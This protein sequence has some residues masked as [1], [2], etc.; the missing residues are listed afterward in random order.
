ME[1]YECIVISGVDGSGKTTLANWLVRYLRSKG[2]RS[3]Y[4]W[5][6]SQHTLAYLISRVLISLG[7]CQTFKNPKGIVITR[8]E[9]HRGMFGENI[10][11]LIEFVSVLPLIIFKVKLP[12]L[13]GYKIVLDRYTIDTTISIALRTRNMS[14]QH[15][16][17]GRLL[18][19]MIPN[20]SAVILLNAD[21]STVLERRPDVEYSLEEIKN[22]I[23]LYKISAR[24]AK[25][26][27][28]NT[29]TLTIEQTI[30]KVSDFLLV[31]PQPKLI[32]MRMP[33]DFSIII[34]TYNRVGKLKT[35]L[36]SI[37]EQEIPPKEVIIVDQSHNSLTS[38]LVIEMKDRYSN[39]QIFLR[40]FHTNQ[41][42]ASRA[43]NLGIDHSIGEIVFFIDDDVIL[44]TD[45]TRNILKVYESH[46]DA[47]GVQ[48]LILN[49]KPFL[50]LKFF[51]SRLENHLRRALFLSHYKD[52]TWKIMPS[53]NDVLP[54][55]TASI[56]PTQRLQGCCSYKRKVLEFFRFDENLKGWSFLED[57]DLSYRVYKSNTGSLY[58]TPDAKLIHKEH[59]HMSASLKDESY[60]KIV[61]RTYVF[62]KLIEQSPRNYAIFSWGIF[63]LLLTT[64]MGTI[65]GRHKEKSNW[66]PIYLIGG[67]LYTLKHLKDIKNLNLKI[68]DKL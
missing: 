21:L 30:K 15:S 8:F 58:V 17:L 41:K 10:W 39:R 26:F 31:K 46:P 25:A 23:L 68:L 24:K 55:P 9:V 52:G 16:F 35:T 47:V 61:N 6:R 3:K 19:K 4:V 65:L 59:V 27:S 29:T 56:I 2:F 22:E 40:Y 66:V 28:V 33:L 67:A 12:L 44:P 18:V 60:K 32:I 43:R 37:F 57:L 36:T 51:S 50:N 7:W 54:I 13:L 45:F 63:G 53:I 5:I 64:I 42:S 34:P 1:P 48:G 14:F 20:D 49:P 38:D 62:F 11:P